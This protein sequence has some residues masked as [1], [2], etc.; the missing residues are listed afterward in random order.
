MRRGYG[1]YFAVAILIVVGG[2]FAYMMQQTQ[3]PMPGSTTPGSGGSCETTAPGG[4]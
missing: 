2:A 3:S 4:G 1:F